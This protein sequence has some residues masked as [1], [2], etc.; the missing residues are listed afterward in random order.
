MTSGEQV[1]WSLPIV[2]LV[3][4]LTCPAYVLFH[5]AG[6]PGTGRVAWIAS[7][8]LAIVTRRFWNLRTRWW[9]WATIVVLAIAHAL[10]VLL[11]PW[12]SVGWIPAPVAIAFGVP[13]L[14]ATVWLIRFVD[15]RMSSR[16]TQPTNGGRD[17]GAR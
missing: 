10:L 14:V 3:V 8:L 6:K 11:L 2:L 1:R 16:Q 15:R 9:F 12:E 4:V 5:L 17:A 13:D 7:V